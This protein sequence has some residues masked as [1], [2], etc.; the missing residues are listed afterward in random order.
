VSLPAETARTI[1]TLGGDP[2]LYIPNLDAANHP[3]R[4]WSSVGLNSNNRWIGWRGRWAE[5]RGNPEYRLSQAVTDADPEAVWRT[6]SHP[7]HD[8][9]PYPPESP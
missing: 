7:P 1:G 8:S 5:A 3:L 9:D 4:P 2:V 6:L